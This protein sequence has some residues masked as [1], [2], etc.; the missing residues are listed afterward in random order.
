MDNLIW[1]AYYLLFA[2]FDWII[3]WSMIKGV[4]RKQRTGLVVWGENQF[5]DNECGVICG[6]IGGIK[7]GST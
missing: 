6:K 7:N 1:F 3:I 5:W 2:L 4:V